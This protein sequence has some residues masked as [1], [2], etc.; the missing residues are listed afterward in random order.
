MKIRHFAHNPKTITKFLFTPLQNVI[1]FLYLVQECFAVPHKA[2]TFVQI[3][4]SPSML[5]WNEL[6]AQD[7]RCGDRSVK[8]KPDP[9]MTDGTGIPS[10]HD[11]QLTQ[12]PVAELKFLSDPVQVFEFDWSS[13]ELSPDARSSAVHVN[14]IHSGNPQVRL[15]TLPAFHYII[16][17]GNSQ[18]LTICIVFLVL[19][20]VFVFTRYS[21]SFFGHFTLKAK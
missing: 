17:S 6:Q 9:K 12:F 2:T 13:K 20:A 3:A 1:T 4:E 8:L 16:Y 11:I 10:V 21:S 5:A 18:Y 14:A 7:I 19:F 15:S